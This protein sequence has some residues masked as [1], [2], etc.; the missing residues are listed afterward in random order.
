MQGAEIMAVLSVTLSIATAKDI[1]KACV[2]V[3]GL[4]CLNSNPRLVLSLAT[5]MVMLQAWVVVAWHILY[6]SSELSEG[7]RARGAEN[8]TTVCF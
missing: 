5:A 8:E 1:P 7:L 4:N 3:L 6:V 2:F